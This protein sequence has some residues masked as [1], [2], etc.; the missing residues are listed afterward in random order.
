[1]N[2]KGKLID[3]H[4]KQFLKIITDYEVESIYLHPEKRPKL[5]R[6]DCRICRY[7]GCSYT[8]MTFKKIA[9]IVPELMG[10][11]NLISD[12]ECDSC[13]A[14]FSKYENDLA[15]FLGIART[16]TAAKAKEVYQHSKTLVINLKHGKMIQPKESL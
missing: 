8:T 12:Y 7:C 9:H 10:N 14:L 13:N 11:A 15:N 6:K 5:K 3:E 16:L 4:E 1:M 2:F